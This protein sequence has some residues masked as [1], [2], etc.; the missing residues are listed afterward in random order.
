MRAILLAIKMKTPKTP[1]SN[2]PGYS[3][4]WDRLPDPLPDYL[5]FGILVFKHAL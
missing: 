1:D 4:A 3:G 5:N 2:P